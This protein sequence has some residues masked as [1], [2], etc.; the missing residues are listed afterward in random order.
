MTSRSCL[1]CLAALGL[2]LQAGCNAL[3][4]ESIRANRADYN[5]AIQT[6]N[7]QELLLNLVRAH[8]RDTLYF[9]TV[10][11]IAAAQSMV[12]S[13]QAS[14]SAG[15][16]QNTPAALSPSASNSAISRITSQ[17]LVLG[18]AGIS[19]SESPTVFYAPIEGEK[20]VRQMMTPMN[21]GVLL[22]LAR[23]GQSVDRVLLVAV[24][25][26]NGLRNA[27]T[28]SAPT[29]SY[30]PEFREFRE[31]VRLLRQLQR[32][33]N[34]E[35]GRSAD[36]KQVELQ[37]L[38]GAAMSP[39][40]MQVKRLLKLAPGLDRFAILPGMTQPNDHTV[41]LSTRSL[42]AAINYLS[43]GIEVPPR[44]AAAG[45]VRV[46]VQNDGNTPFDWQELLG[47]VFHVLSSDT[48]PADAAVA[49]A[50]RGTWF[51]IPDNDLDSKSTFVLLTQL[52]ALHSV[53]PT[54]GGPVLS[55]PVGG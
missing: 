11:R 36:G 19:V 53:P 39:P 48:R 5:I 49:I 34:L 17:G 13:A 40:A 31:A 15:F 37:I 54:P 18:P 23:S 41:A 22:L 43:Q 1:A 3:G 46:T 47:G 52:I 30:E 21:P 4:P 28:A 51:Y 9:T 25:E 26:M 6:T 50:Y 24:Q 20:F 44:D 42:I 35:L 32:E 2:S 12:R 29:P 55:I 38:H 33:Q 10:E 14:A 16:V 8:Y 27:P 7:D 45:R